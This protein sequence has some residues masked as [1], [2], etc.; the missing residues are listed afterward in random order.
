MAPSLRVLAAIALVSVCA[1]SH[2]ETVVTKSGTE[3]RE[4]NAL[5]NTIKVSNERGTAIIGKGAVDPKTLGLPMYPGAIEA[6]TGAMETT[7]RVGAEHQ[8]SLTTADSFGKVYDWYRQHM[9]AGS[10]Q[11]HLEVAGGSV[12]S[13]EIGRLDDKDQKSVM[14]TESGDKTAILLTR[15]VKNS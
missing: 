9:P 14:I 1:C 5:R 3:T 7:S 12:A 8:V 10:E 6:E 13:F 15:V 2:K 11:T 4:T